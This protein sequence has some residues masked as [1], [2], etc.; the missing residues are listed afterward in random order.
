MTETATAESSQKWRTRQIIM[1]IAA[2]IIEGLI[3]SFY[4][5]SGIT[6]G[7]LFNEGNLSYTAIQ[8]VI[9]VSTIVHAVVPAFAAMLAVKK[10][11]ML[12][13]TLGFILLLIGM[14]GTAVSTTFILLLL[15]YGIILSFGLSALSFGVIFGLI[16]P[17]FN[18][19]SAI[20]ISAI[21]TVSSTV[22]CVLLA[23]GMQILTDA[24]GFTRMILILGAL[25]ACLYPLCFLFAGKKEEKELA[26]QKKE[27]NLK[28]EL[29]QILKSPMIYLLCGY[30]LVVGFLEGAGNHLY[31]GMI[32]HGI[33]GLNATIS[34]DAV[35]IASAAGALV[36]AVLVTRIRR[37]MQFLSL[38][39]IGFGL[40]TICLL[41]INYTNVPLSVAIV[42]AVFFIIS[43]AYPMQILLIRARYPALLVGTVL[44]IVSI[45]PDIGKSISNI[46]G[47]VIFD[48]F[49]SFVPLVTIQSGCGIFF[50]LA[51]LI[52]SI[53]ERKRHK[54]AIL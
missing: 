29:K 28:N 8:T 52:F 49:G 47:G 15:S 14:I 17:L 33:S 38:L 24:V 2:M 12:V 13:L 19:K 36:A 40:G 42:S 44:C 35:T 21:F 5:S 10:S 25:F 3:G 48:A 43:F 30:F 6:S 18:E 32:S 7:L 26:T 50:G 39:L 31:T 16:S 34:T 20:I 46:A 4:Y 51:L 22:F 37:K 9:T 45:F 27:A 1:V 11:N 41:L 23:P 53:A 54:E